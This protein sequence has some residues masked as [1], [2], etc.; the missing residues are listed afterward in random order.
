MIV[1]PSA[2]SFIE[3]LRREGFCVVRARNDVLSGIRKTAD[4]LKTGRLVICEGCA[5]TL[6]ELELYVWEGGGARDAPKKEND[7][8][9]DDIRYFAA[10][11]AECGE[12]AA[13]TW[14]ER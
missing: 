5:D 7:H 13:A 4:A 12:E 2:A 1:D 6:R 11:A 9:M 8:A 14:V 10:T 3:A